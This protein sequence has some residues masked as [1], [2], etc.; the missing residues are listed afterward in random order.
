MGDP[1]HGVFTATN[2]PVP[3]TLY[4]YRTDIGLTFREYFLCPDA[5][6]N[7]AKYF[8]ESLIRGTSS[9]PITLY[10]RPTYD[11]GDTFFAHDVFKC[12]QSGNKWL[13]IRL[14]SYT[15]ISKMFTALDFSCLM[16]KSMKAKFH[17][18]GETLEHMRRMLINC[19][20]LFSVASQQD[21]AATTLQSPSAPGM[22]LLIVGVMHM[23]QAL[24]EPC[25]QK[26]WQDR[27]IGYT[28]LTFEV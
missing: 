27:S 15:A 7:D 3:P 6:G 2:D 17:H 4:I 9:L 23:L 13:S 25:L 20:F 10:A 24:E 5:S 22:P 11:L 26:E 14:E 18:E 19:K 16:P 28:S 12:F 21:V 1:I 8:V